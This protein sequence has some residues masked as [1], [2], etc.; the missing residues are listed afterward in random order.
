MTAE[1]LKKIR[2]DLGLT[3]TKFAQAIGYSQKAVECWEYKYGKIPD[4]VVRLIE[5]TFKKSN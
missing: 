2:T 3:Q 1:E 5:L 4:R